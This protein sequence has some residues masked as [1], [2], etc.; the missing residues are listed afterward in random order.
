M[1]SA[2][3]IEVKSTA[4][5]AVRLEAIMA[6]FPLP[7]VRFSKYVSGVMAGNFLAGPRGNCRA[8]LGDS[9]WRKRN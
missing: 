1:P 6:D 2:A 3:I 4:E 8:S 9:F 5:Q 7:R